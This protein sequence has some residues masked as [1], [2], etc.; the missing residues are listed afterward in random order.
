AFCEDAKFGVEG[1]NDLV[2]E[3][4]FK[5]FKG[6]ST[7]TAPKPSQIQTA[8]ADL[9]AEVRATLA[10]RRAQILAAF[11]ERTALVGFQGAF[12]T[13]DGAL[14][15]VQQAATEN[16]VP[17]G[18]RVRGRGSRT[19]RRRSRRGASRYRRSTRQP[20]AAQRARRG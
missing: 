15:G 7:Q 19:G 17:W 10:I 3:I 4:R 5:V 16:D 18:A 11:L 9:T 12:D 13:T 1:P 2:Y 6:P 14:A 8:P 20:G